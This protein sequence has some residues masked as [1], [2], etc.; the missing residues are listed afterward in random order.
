MGEADRHDTAKMR[1]LLLR[2]ERAEY[3]ALMARARAE[4]RT[5]NAILR[6]ALRAYMEQPSDA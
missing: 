3:D 5:M 4:D 2:L 6:R 1:S